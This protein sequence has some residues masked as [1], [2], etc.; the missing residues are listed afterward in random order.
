MQHGWLCT[1]TWQNGRSVFG[2]TWSV[3]KL[4]FIALR[5][6]QSFVEI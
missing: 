3:N 5:L 2:N 6:S 4:M 1:R